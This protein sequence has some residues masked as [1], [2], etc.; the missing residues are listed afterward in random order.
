MSRKKHDPETIPLVSPEQFEAAMRAVLNAPKS[1]VE[2]QLAE[3]QATNKR[4]R[5][6]RKATP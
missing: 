3:M 6:E 4:R 1:E 5:E 2:E